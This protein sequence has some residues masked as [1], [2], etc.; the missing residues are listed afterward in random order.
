MYIATGLLSEIITNNAAAALMYPIAATLG[1]SLRIPPMLVSVSIMLGASASFI[2]PVGYQCNLMVYAAG[3]YKVC[4]AEC[5]G[6]G[7]QRCMHSHPNNPYSSQTANFF[8]YGVPMQLVQIG[9]AMVALCFTSSP[10]LVTGITMGAAIVWVAGMHHGVDTHV[11]TCGHPHT[12][13]CFTVL[14]ILRLAGAG[15]LS[16][17]ALGKRGRKL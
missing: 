13:S 8:R 12:L 11:Q 14:G 2:I 4:V 10:W 1:D 9:G 3:N 17:I 6:G 7:D 15:I 5:S 16:R